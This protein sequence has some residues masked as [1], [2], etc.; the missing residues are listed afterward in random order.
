[1]Y[2]AFSR[3]DRR[4][5]SRDLARYEGG[6]SWGSGEAAPGLDLPEEPVRAHEAG[7]ERPRARG[8]AV[9]EALP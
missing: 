6:R 3:I 2:H 8:R 4:R 9:R 5:C 1:M 7:E